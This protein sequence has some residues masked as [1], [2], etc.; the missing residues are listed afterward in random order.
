MPA[1]KKAAVKASGR[2]KAEKKNPAKNGAP[3]RAPKLAAIVRKHN[4]LPRQQQVL[5]SI[6]NG[7]GRVLG[8]I[9]RDA[10]YS[11]RTA[12][13]PGEL[14]QTK[15]MRD[16]LAELLAPIEKIAERIN[17]GLDAIETET[18]THVVGSKLKG[19]ERIELEH[20]DKIAWTERRKYAELAVRLK[21]LMPGSE[22]EAGATTNKITVNFVHV[23]A[24]AQP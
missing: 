10:G 9:I 11:E 20:V 18:F 14:L 6:A 8:E 7:P 3:A 21:G 15:R 4:L 17:E 1:K 12:R 13:H 2:T 22:F 23:A 16:A 5:E 19:T 24:L